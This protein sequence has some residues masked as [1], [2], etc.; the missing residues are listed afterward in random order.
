M[1]APS[2]VVYAL[3]GMH[4]HLIHNEEPRCLRNVDSFCRAV[5]FTSPRDLFALS[6][7]PSLLNHV[8]FTNGQRLS[9]ISTTSNGLRAGMK[10]LNIFF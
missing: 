8:I 6:K 7:I 3:V 2:L 9:R 10:A 1:R 4:Q 5:Y